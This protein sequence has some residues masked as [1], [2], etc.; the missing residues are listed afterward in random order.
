MI[1]PQVHLRNVLTNLQN[2]DSAGALHRKHFLKRF[3][4]PA[5]L[6]S[7]RGRLNIRLFLL[8]K[9]EPPP[10]QSVNLT[11]TRVSWLRI[12]QSFGVITIR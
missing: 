2:L 3:P 8:Y 7:K 9:K 4:L 1:L 12:V 10:L 11:P 6:L 5:T